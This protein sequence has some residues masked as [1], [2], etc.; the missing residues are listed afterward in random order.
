M[1]SIFESSKKNLYAVSCSI[2]SLSWTVLFSPFQAAGNKVLG[3]NEQHV[4][5]QEFGAEE[6]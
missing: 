5:G 6:W 2:C 1:P 4:V 3:K